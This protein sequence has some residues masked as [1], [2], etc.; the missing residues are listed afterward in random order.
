MYLPLKPPLPSGIDVRPGE[1]SPKPT[2]SGSSKLPDWKLNYENP[3][4][5][6]FE[7]FSLEAWTKLHAY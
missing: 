6:L 2:Y 7:H 4:F 3:C 5:F 1:L